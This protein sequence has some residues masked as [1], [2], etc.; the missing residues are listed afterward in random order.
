T[1]CRG[2]GGRRRSPVFDLAQGSSMIR[3]RCAAFGAGLAALLACGA[4]TAKEHPASVDVWAQS[5]ADL[6]PDPAMRFGKLANGMR[7]VVMKNATPGGQASFRLWIHGGSLDETD[8][9]QGLAHFLEHMA[10]DGSKHVPEGEMVK[11]LERHGL[12]FGAD[13]NAYTAQEETVFKLD[14]PKADIDTVD[15]SLML[16]RE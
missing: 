3:N 10:F 8:A 5:Y 11:I 6:P 7:Y 15:T 13:T 1:P 16:L 9:E 12:A 14:L 4:A 2:H